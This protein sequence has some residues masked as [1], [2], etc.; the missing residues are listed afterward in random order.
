MYYFHTL[1]LS[2]YVVSFRDK[3]LPGSKNIH[4]PTSFSPPSQRETKGAKRP[5]VTVFFYNRTIVQH[6]DPLQ[7]HT[8][9]TQPM[10]ARRYAKSNPALTAN[11]AS[12]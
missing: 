2:F 5:S 12:L 7:L 8:K 1:D 10:L 3:L 11:H 4:F 6:V 9:I